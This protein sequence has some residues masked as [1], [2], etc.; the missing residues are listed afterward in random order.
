MQGEKDALNTQELAGFNL[1]MGKG[2]CGSCHF[3]PLFSGAVPPL[4][5]KMESEVLGVPANTDTINAKIDADLGKYNL[6]K[7]PHQK[8]AF[9]TPSLRNIALTAPYMHNGV[10]QTLDEVI[11]FYNKGGGAGLGI[12]LENQ[13]LSPD[14]LQLSETEK[15]QLI[16]FLNALTDKAVY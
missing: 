9:K 4:F 13:T 6:Y 16:A 15:K 1:F 12:I 5:E 3:L 7:I 8:H 2:K 11:D 10:Y 14:K